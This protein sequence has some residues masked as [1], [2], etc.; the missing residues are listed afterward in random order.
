MDLPLPILPDPERP[1]G[2]GKTGVSTSARRRDGAE[3]ATGLRIDLLD[4]ILRNLKQV[5]PIES[6]ARVRGDIERAQRL[7]VCRIEGTQFI[8]KSEPDVL[9]VVAD[10]M[11]VVGPRERSKLIYDLGSYSIHACKLIDRRWR[12]E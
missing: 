1:V 12:R 5:P 10:S 8:S 4:A 7:P 9:A 11:D 3:D 2:P 6:G